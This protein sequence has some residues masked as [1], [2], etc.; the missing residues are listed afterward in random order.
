MTR[1]PSCTTGYFRRAMTALRGEPKTGEGRRTA[2]NH[3]GE[4]MLVN[5]TIKSTPTVSL[6]NATHKRE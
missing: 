1:I 4:G 6:V 2:E 3:S 5:Q